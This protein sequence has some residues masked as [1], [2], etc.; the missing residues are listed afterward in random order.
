MVLFTQ[1]ARRFHNWL[2]FAPASYEAYR[3]QDT[4]TSAT[5][6]SY[7][8]DASHR[9]QWTTEGGDLWAADQQLTT[10]DPNSNFPGY[11]T[12]DYSVSEYYGYN[13]DDGGCGGDGQQAE[14]RVA[15][16]SAEANQQWYAGGAESYDGAAYQ[17]G[18]SESSKQ[19]WAKSW[20]ADA[21]DDDGAAAASGYY[22]AWTPETPDTADDGTGYGYGGGGGDEGAGEWAVAAVAETPQDWSGSTPENAGYYG[23]DNAGGVLAT[24]H[25]AVAG[26]A[27]AWSEATA[28]GW[29]TG[30]A[31]PETADAPTTANGG[32]E[33]SASNAFA[34][35]GGGGSDVSLTGGGDT[36]ET[37]PSGGSSSRPW[38]VNEFGQRVSGDWVEYY[39]ESAQAAYFYNT[40]SGEV[41]KI[42]T[43]S[44]RHQLLLLFTL[45]LFFLV[46]A[47]L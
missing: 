22:A 40:A 23:Y 35:G 43:F 20:S 6:D 21:Y 36:A 27:Q 41:R 15:S 17:Q 25:A 32:E 7:F 28:T 4:A 18:P 39:D 24:D 2:P 34:G 26:G 37:P 44:I 38:S 46:L 16:W 11:D 14:D 31:T 30:W 45:L 9:Q 1:G 5:A 10:A 47:R 3:A 12:Y 42:C 8:S 13:N 19:D 33:T 29:D